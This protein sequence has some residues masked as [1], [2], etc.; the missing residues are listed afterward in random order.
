VEPERNLLVRIAHMYYEENQTQQRISERL[1]CSRMAVSRYLQKAKDTGV[2]HIQIDYDGIF[3]DLEQALKKKFGLED[4]AI[5]PYENEPRLKRMLAQTAA[6]ILLEKL[7]PGH[8]VGVG[9]G[10]TLALVPEFLEDTPAR[11]VAFVPLLGGYGQISIHMHANQIASR[12]GEVFRCKS[13]ILNAPALV[14]NISLK[15]GLMEDPAIKS[16]L[17]IARHADIALVGIGAPFA[18]ESTLS[19]SGYYSPDDIDSLKASQ[20][21][22]NL[23]SIIYI[24]KDGKERKFDMVERNIGVTAEEY[25][26]IPLKMA[27]AGGQG[28]LFAIRSAI[29]HR[30]VDI[31]VTDEKTAEFCLRNR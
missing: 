28:K 16:T 31:I 24:D 19:L 8:V 2:V 26:H 10:S 14:S 25:K 22:C 9:W 27:V 29:E 5:V 23:L 7:R 17:D 15:D 30:L 20:V 11:D 4:A 1:G 3:P 21:E 6:N 12:L 13:Y 18:E